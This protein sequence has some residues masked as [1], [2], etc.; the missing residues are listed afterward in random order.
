MRLEG[1]SSF[2][3]LESRFSIDFQQIVIDVLLIFVITKRAI[4]SHMTQPLRDILE[5]LLR[6]EHQIHEPFATAVVIVLLAK[7]QM[8]NLR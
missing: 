2:D 4:S 8:Y 5:L 6:R 1:P 7:L 3:S